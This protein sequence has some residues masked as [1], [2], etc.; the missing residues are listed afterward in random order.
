MMND[1]QY[2]RV[3]NSA[4]VYRYNNGSKVGNRKGLGVYLEYDAYRGAPL[5]YTHTFTCDAQ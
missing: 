2:V 3:L 5:C 4:I 1:I